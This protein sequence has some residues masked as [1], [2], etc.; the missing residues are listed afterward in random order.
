M[1]QQANILIVD[2]ELEIRQLLKEFLQLKGYAALTAANGVEA[3]TCLK[4]EKV[5]LALIDMWMPGM[6]GLDILRSIRASDPSVGVIMMTG[7]CDAEI[8]RQAI[9]S[10]AHDYL[11]KPLDFRRLEGA[12]RA[13]LTGAPQASPTLLA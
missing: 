8:A 11:T 9:D 7:L 12:I 13:G 2:D 4:A 3:L 6:N 5:D 10:G 1:K